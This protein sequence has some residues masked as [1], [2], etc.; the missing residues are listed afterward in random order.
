MKGVIPFVEKTYRVMPEMKKRAIARLSMG[1]GHTLTETNGNPGIFG[2][3]AV[4]SSA[5]RGRRPIQ[6][7]K[8]RT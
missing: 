3:I 4:F 2:W 8:L 7:R 1:G 6:I 5:P